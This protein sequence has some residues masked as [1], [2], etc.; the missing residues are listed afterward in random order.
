MEEIKNRVWKKYM[1]INGG[2]FQEWH[3]GLSPIE[4]NLFDRHFQE[5]RA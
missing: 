1:T 4:K 3:E 5:I 2:D